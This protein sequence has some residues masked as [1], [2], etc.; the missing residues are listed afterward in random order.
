[1]FE[2]LYWSKLVLRICLDFFSTKLC[3]FE[4]NIFSGIRK[5]TWPFRWPWPINN[6][7]G[8]QLLLIL[9]FQFS[10]TAFCSEHVL[11]QDFLTR[12]VASHLM[13]FGKSLVVGETAERINLVSNL[14]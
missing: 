6:A 10:D 9:L 13:T 7:I 8:G 11:E 5:L 3:S 4:Q 2:L 12:C 14:K 1:M